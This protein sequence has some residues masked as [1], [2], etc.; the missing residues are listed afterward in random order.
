MKVNSNVERT[1]V[2]G[3]SGAIIG[4]T[5]IQDSHY[6]INETSKFS[7]GVPR[8]HLCLLVV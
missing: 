7:P 5:M 3:G 1:Q 4:A 6:L 2:L 8:L